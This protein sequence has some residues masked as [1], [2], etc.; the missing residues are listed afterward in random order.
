MGCPVGNRFTA[1]GD[2]YE[3]DCSFT[4]LEPYVYSIPLAV[5][6]N[7]GIPLGIVIA[8]SERRDVHSLF[9]DLLAEKGFSRNELFEIP[10]LSDAGKA[11]RS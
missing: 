3:L 8:P 9:A 4:A 1:S 6:A 11:L 2:Y 5:R 7:V 10:L